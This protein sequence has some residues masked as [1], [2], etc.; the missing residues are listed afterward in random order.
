MDQKL[1]SVLEKFPYLSY[2]SH[3]GQSYLGIIQNAD[4]QLISMYVLDETM[5]APTRALFLSLGE[6][7]WWESNRQ[8]PIH[9]FHKDRF[10]IFRP[11]LKHFARKDFEIVAGPVVSLQD[12]IAKRVRKRQVTLL[13]KID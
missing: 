13:R 9:I 2:G 8:I 7:W 12:T 10:R 1:Q 6:S 5:E 3:D 11:Y 4:N